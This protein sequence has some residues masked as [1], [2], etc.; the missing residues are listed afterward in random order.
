MTKS[1][2]HCAVLLALANFVYVSFQIRINT[3]SLRCIE[4]IFDFLNI[5]ISKIA[6]PDVKWTY[7][8]NIYNKITKKIVPKFICLIKFYLQQ[9]STYFR[10]FETLRISS[11]FAYVTQTLFANLAPTAGCCEIGCSWR[12]REN[13]HLWRQCL[14]MRVGKIR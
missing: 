14:T 7:S 12:I 8:F 2:F 6:H 9:T 10:S 11:T 3:I 5:P 1:E 13:T 4:N